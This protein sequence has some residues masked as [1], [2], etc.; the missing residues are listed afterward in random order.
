MSAKTVALDHP[1]EV[2]EEC[3]LALRR[4]RDRLRA[5]VGALVAASEQLA[6]YQAD[7][8]RGGSQDADVA[9]DLAEA[10]LDLGLERAEMARL[11]DVE[12]ALYRLAAGSYG[13][14]TRCDAAI[15]L[16]RLQALPW[17]RLCRAC[18]GAAA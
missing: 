14:C 7:E 4:E 11:T 18:A 3:A 17:T 1:S 8:G 6:L 5:V 10:E 12:D 9:S 16:D 15:G 13:V 2:Y